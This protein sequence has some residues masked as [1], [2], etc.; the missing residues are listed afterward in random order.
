MTTPQQKFFGPDYPAGLG[1]DNQ[2]VLGVGRFQ[3]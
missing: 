1:Q 2:D 3:P